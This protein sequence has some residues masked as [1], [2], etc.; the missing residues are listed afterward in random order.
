[1]YSTVGSNKRASGILRVPGKLLDL[2]LPGCFPIELSRTFHR[3]TGLDEK[4]KVTLIGSGMFGE[5][6]SVRLNNIELGKGT[7]TT[8]RHDVTLLL[9]DANRLTILA[10][11]DGDGH[12]ALRIDDVRLEINGSRESSE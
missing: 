10:E 11:I 12:D 6:Y 7:G 4:S 9:H 5:S 1:M 8:F 2:D 3:P